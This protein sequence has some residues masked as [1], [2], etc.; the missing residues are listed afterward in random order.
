M[1]DNGPQFPGTYTA[2]VSVTSPV[3]TLVQ[4]VQATDQDSVSNCG[5]IL[6]NDS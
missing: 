4:S 5:E 6:V 3:G 1:N 2:N